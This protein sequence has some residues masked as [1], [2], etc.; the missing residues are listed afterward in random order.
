MK[1]SPEVWDFIVLSYVIC[2]TQSKSVTADWKMDVVEMAKYVGVQSTEYI[3]YA[4]MILGVPYTS[5]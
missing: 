2:D 4:N 5:K 1:K 3:M